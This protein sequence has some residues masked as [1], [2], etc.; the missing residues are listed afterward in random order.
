MPGRF[1]KGPLD[2]TKN[3]K[4]FLYSLENYFE[5]SESPRGEV[6][7]TIIYGD[8]IT[9]EDSN[10]V[11]DCPDFPCEECDGST[12]TPTLSIT[13]TPTTTPTPLPTPTPSSYFLGLNSD[14]ENFIP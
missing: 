1:F 8:L 4:A 7:S 12:P 14:F 2:S 13:P 5:D 9:N 10:F 11:P 3:I 6:R